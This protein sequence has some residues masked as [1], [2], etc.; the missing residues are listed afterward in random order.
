MNDLEQGQNSAS[1]AESARGSVGNACRCRRRAAI[2]RASIAAMS[3]S[4]RAPSSRA[5]AEQPG[6]EI[7][8]DQRITGGAV[9][10]AVL[11]AEVH[12][13]TVEPAGA[14]APHQPPRQPHRAEPRPVQ[15]QVARPPQLGGDEA[16]VEPG[17]VGD[18]DPARQRREDLIGDR[19]ERGRVADHVVGDAGDR[20]DDRRNGPARIDQRFEHHLPPAAL[21]HDH[22]DL[23]DAVARPRAHAG[24][25]HVHHGEGALI[26]QRGS[27]RFGHQPPAAVR[28]LAHPR[29][30]AE[31]G[32]RHPLADRRA[33]RRG[34]R[35]TGVTELE[36]GGGTVAEREQH[37]LGQRALRVGRRAD[38][39]G[40]RRSGSDM[41]RGPPPPRASS[42]PS[43]VITVRCLASLQSSKARKLTAGT[44]RNPAA[45][46]SQSVD[47]LRR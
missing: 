40:A 46:S 22:R 41:Q 13:E 31:Q 20:T 2:R 37:A 14:D 4:V 19:G 36:G 24:G 6:Q 45:W 34:G 10:G 33:G 47:S 39:S 8:G 3:C 43:M 16:P 42:L 18:E 5:S 15:R 11:Q 44:T 7:G 30:G 21:D 35:A 29:I 26:Q 25:L 1:G 12:L 23:G 17:V 27:L 32:D 9:A 38:H 28:E